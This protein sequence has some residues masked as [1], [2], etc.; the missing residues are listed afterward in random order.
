MVEYVFVSW[1]LAFLPLVLNGFLKLSRSDCLGDM[2]IKQ[3]I[4]RKTK[5]SELS[6]QLHLSISNMEIMFNFRYS[7]LFDTLPN[8][9]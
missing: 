9:L 2:K 3:F 1:R 7:E 5:L 8:T 4:N 6:E